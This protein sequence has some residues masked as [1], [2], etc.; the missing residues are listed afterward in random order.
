[1]RDRL[2]DGVA[3]TLLVYWLGTQQ[4]ADTAMTIRLGGRYIGGE[5]EGTVAK[6]KVY[7]FKCPEDR[8]VLTDS[9]DSKSS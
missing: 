3:N 4:E 7:R 8:W 2:N 5:H 9:A 6:A 1:V